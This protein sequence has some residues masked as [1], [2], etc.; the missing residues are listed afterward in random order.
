VVIT[1]SIEARS[2]LRRSGV[3]VAAE[4]SIAAG[5]DVVLLTGSAS[6]KLAFPR[7]LRRARRSKSFRHRVERS[8]GRVLQ[9]KREL[10]LTGT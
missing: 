9:L 1:D 6:W 5:A 7:L 4:R 8:A 10:G 2:V 3:A